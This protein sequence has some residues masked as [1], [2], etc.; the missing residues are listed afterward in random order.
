MKT[1]IIPIEPQPVLADPKPPGRWIWRPE[2]PITDQ[3][4][5][6]NSN[7]SWWNDDGYTDSLSEYAPGPLEKSAKVETVYDGERW[8]WVIRTRK[9][10]TR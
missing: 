4:R 7:V 1:T 10:K 9:R 6:G 8:V 3:C 2:L 5:G